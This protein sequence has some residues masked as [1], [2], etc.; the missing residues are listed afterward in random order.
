[1]EQN[2]EKRIIPEGQGCAF[3]VSAIIVTLLLDVWACPVALKWVCEMWGMV[4]PYS[5]A[6]ASWVFARL[7]VF[8]L[9]GRK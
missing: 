7:V 6:L 4:I 9:T 2:K 1:M 3:W 5:Q 8:L